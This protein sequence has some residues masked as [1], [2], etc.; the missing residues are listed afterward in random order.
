MKQKKV[1]ISLGII[2]FVSF[3]LNVFGIRWGLPGRN[4]IGLVF[5][6]EKILNILVPVMSETRQ[7]IRQ[8]IKS[9]GDKYLKDYDENR[10]VDIDDGFFTIPLTVGTINAMRTYLLRTYYPDEHTTLTALSNINPKEKQFSPK[11]LVPGCFYVY[12]S[13]LWLGI[14]NLFHLIKLGDSAFYLEHPWELGRVYLAG[15]MLLIFVFLFC[16][17][18]VWLI[19]N[20]I[21][22]SEV[23]LVSAFLFGISPVL[24]M[25]NHFGYYYGFTLLFVLLSFL[26]SLKIYTIGNLKYYIASAICA[27]IAMS[28]VSLY[29]VAIVFMIIAGL[30][31]LLDGKRLYEVLKNIAVGIMVLVGIFIAIHIFLILDKE[32][33]LKV[34][35]FEGGDFKFSPDFFYYLNHNTIFDFLLFFSLVY[36]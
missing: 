15:R 8:M 2:I 29:G 30:M 7:E 28:I 18:L 24:N 6:N 23:G 35:R 16:I 26:Y 3:L 9:P 17:Y 14:C 4:I 10:I 21:W 19:S 1:Y 12:A 32:T 36:S 27:A 20:N 33:F 13:G 22:G 25:W 11:V 31:T 34:L 5:G